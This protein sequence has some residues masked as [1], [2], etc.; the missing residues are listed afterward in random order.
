MYHNLDSTTKWDAGRLGIG[1]AEPE[2]LEPLL[3]ELPP[4]HP[5]AR[6]YRWSPEFLAAHRS[7][8]RCD[9]I[10][11]HLGSISYPI[12]GQHRGRIAT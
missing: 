6:S 1:L 3:T 9:P 5:Q 2:E 8:G 4:A 11:E 7:F 10:L 12:G